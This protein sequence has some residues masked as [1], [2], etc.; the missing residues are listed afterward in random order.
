MEKMI[1]IL[2]R[3]TRIQ[4]LLQSKISLTVLVFVIQLRGNG[5]DSQELSIN[6]FLS[7]I[8]GGKSGDKSVH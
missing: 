2:K 5:G 7:M 3:E 4:Y 8:A 6:M 1:I